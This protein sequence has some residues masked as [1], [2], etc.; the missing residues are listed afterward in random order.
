ME[1]FLSNIYDLIINIINSSNIFGP[2]LACFLIF[3]ESILPVLPLFVFITIT[4]ISYGYFFGFLIS[5]I[6]TILGCYFS[7]YLCRTF[8]NKLFTKNVRQIEKLNKVMKKI[9][10]INFSSLVLL[11]SIPFT[12]AFLVNIAASLSNMSFKKFSIA[13]II[14]KI[15][16]V[17]FWGFIG[18]SLLESLKNPKILVIIFIMLGVSYLLSKIVIKRLNIE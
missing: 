6:L 7:F 13:I 4:F 16:I 3:I 8:F 15:F 2:L 17:F 1:E 5:Y 12:P 9:D 11:V 10:N 18:T 14:G